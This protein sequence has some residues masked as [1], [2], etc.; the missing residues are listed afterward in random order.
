MKTQVVVPSRGRSHR[1]G[2]ETLALFP[3]AMVSV[4]ESE[5]DDYRQTVPDAQLL[6]HPGRAEL[7]NL[8]AIRNWIIDN[9]PAADALLMVDDDILGFRAVVGWRVR[10]TRDPATIAAVVESTAVCARDAGA[11]LFGF[12]QLRNPSF[13]R[14]F[15][16]IRLNSWVGGIFG[17]V[18]GHG[19]RFDLELPLHDD[20]DLSLQSLMKHRIVWAD[21]RW[22][23][24]TQVANN[25]GGLA[26]ERHS[27]EY[28]RQHQRLLQKWGQYVAMYEPSR[29]DGHKLTT[30]AT[31]INV[32][33][34]QDVATPH[35]S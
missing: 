28:D 27:K 30:M 35:G 7:K 21:L 1:I 22:C 26:N 5:M 19:L 31:A 18:E 23:F 10:T 13:F 34:Q 12:S 4:D 9:A 17:L 2:E 29:P 11:K 32:R 16:P 20:V 25:V 15:R 6:P 8:S 3:E 14:P 24:L 33:R